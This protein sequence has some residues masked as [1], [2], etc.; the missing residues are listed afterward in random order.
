MERYSNKR[1]MFRRG[2]R[3]SKAPSLADLGYPVADGSRICNACGEKW[4]PV[5]I[6]GTCPKCGTENN[7]RAIETEQRGAA[8]A[9]GQASDD[10]A[11]KI[12]TIGHTGEAVRAMPS[13][14][15]NALASGETGSQSAPHHNS[16]AQVPTAGNCTSAS[17]DVQ[18]AS[19]EPTWDM[20]EA[21]FP[22]SECERCDYLR[23]YRNCEGRFIYCSLLKPWDGRGRAPQ[24]SDCRGVSND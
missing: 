24:P 14:N 11:S 23:G 1:A 2:G 10:M 20:V 5:L 21:Y 15:D 9:G 8:A 17:I 4:R 3:F 16:A 19:A 7:S 12:N 6:T 22:G 13:L 18:P